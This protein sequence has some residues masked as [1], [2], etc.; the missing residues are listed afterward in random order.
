MLTSIRP[1]YQV[2]SLLTK[3]IALTKKKANSR[4]D[5]NIFVLNNHNNKINKNNSH[6]TSK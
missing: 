1:T 5:F 6:N 2:T 3:V 4:Q